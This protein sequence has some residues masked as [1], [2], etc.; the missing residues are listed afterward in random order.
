[1]TATLETFVDVVH[2]HRIENPSM[3]IIGE[4]VALREKIQWFERMMLQQQPFVNEAF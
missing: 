2:Q 4:V 1:V 3:I